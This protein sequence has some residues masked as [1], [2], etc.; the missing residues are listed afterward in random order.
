MLFRT[1]FFN[2]RERQKKA[3]NNFGFLIRKKGKV[4]LEQMT[5]LLCFDNKNGACS[6]GKDFDY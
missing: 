5:D 1:H 6:R 2:E 3:A 4:H